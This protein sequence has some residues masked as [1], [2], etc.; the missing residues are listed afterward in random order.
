MPISTHKTH[1][2]AH[3]S[4]IVL[5]SQQARH[6]KKQVKEDKSWAKAA[7]IE[8]EVNQLSVLSTI[9]ELEDTIEKNEEQVCVHTNRPDLYPTHKLL[10][11][12]ILEGPDSHKE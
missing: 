8:K 11:N 5:E 3:P 1:V 9:V 2:S 6:T 4:H 10:R 7:A 12:M